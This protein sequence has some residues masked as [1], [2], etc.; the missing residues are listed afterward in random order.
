MT[1]IVAG[2][3]AGT[4]VGAVLGYHV[5]HQLTWFVFTHKMRANGATS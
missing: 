3:L 4:V 5:G 1:F 2:A